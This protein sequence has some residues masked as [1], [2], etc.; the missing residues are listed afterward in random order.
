M[1]LVNRRRAEIQL[2]PSQGFYIARIRLG[3]EHG[4]V[5]VNPARLVPRRHEENSPIRWLT[6]DEETQLRAI[7]ASRY[8]TEVPAFDLALHTGLRRS[9]QYHLSVWCR[10]KGE[11]KHVT[12]GQ[13]QEKARK[14]AQA[15]WGKRGRTIG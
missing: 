7:I 5:S 10:V 2:Q 9:E 3:I 12:L 4:K 1:H 13:R 14:A 11:E 8:S 15:R 6:A